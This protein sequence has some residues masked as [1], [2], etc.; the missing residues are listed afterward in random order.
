MNQ[1]FQPTIQ[2]GKALWKMMQN[3]PV[4]LID[5]PPQPGPRYGYGKPP[6]KALYE[7]IEKERDN[8]HRCLADILQLKSSLCEIPVHADEVSSDSGLPHW[9]NPWFP[10]LD[11]AVLYSMIAIGKPSIYLEIG[12]G[13]STRFARR[14]VTD[15]DVPCRI[16]SIDPQPRAEID[17]LCDE[18]HRSP[19][20][21]VDLT[22]FESLEAGDILFVDSS[23]RVLMNSDVQVIFMDVLPRIKPGVIVHFHDIWLPYDYPQR[24]IDRYYSEQ[25]MLAALLLFGDQ[26]EIILANRFITDDPE[27][28]TVLDLLWNSSELSTVASH[29]GSFWIQRKQ[30]QVE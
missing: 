14:A 7:M 16:V 28:S 21:T 11:A 22:V 29:G 25:Y 10:G 5:D 23:H 17:A 13:F 8:Y 2:A 4:I 26:Y 6:H 3:Q 9:D 12:S 18:V 19:L 1:A 20:E 15:C 30:G 27:L 24:W